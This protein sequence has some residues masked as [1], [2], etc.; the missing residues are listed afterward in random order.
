[1]KK[2]W[3]VT[4]WFSSPELGKHFVE[5]RQFRFWLSA[6]FFK[7]ENDRWY[8]WRQTWGEISRAAS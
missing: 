8:N 3:I 5:R 6:W 7:N 1:M 4:V 2:P